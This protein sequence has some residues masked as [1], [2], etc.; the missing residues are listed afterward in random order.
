MIKSLYV[1]RFR[2]MKKLTIPLGKKVTVIAGQNATCKS[3][4]LGMIGQPFGLKSERTIF[5]KPFSTKFSDIFKFS[6]TYDLPGEHEYQIEFYDSSLFGKNVEYI[7][8]Y[9]RASSDTS[10]IR[11]VVGKTRGKGDG[12][13]DYPVIYLGLKRTYPIGELREITESIPTLTQT[14]IEMFNKWYKEIFFPQEKVSPIQ[15]TS[16]LQKD[17]LAV[18]SEKYDYFANS[19]GQDNIGQILGAIISFDRLKTKLGEGYKGGI[20]LIDELDAT[21]F[22]AAQTN[23]VDLFYKLAGKYNLQ[24][25]FTTHSLYTLEHIIE[26]RQHNNNDTEVLYFTNVYGKLDLIVAP[27][28]QRIRSDLNMATI[29]PSPIPKI[30]LYCEDV[31][32][33]WFIKRLLGPQKTKYLNFC[34]ATFGGNFLSSLAEKNIPEFNNSIIIL[35]GDKKPPK[36]SHNVL[37]LPGN[38]NPE[39]V[40]RQLLEELPPDHDFWKNDLGY[41]KQVFEK[42]LSKQTSGRYDDR[43]KMKAWFN[44]QKK[45]WGRGGNNIFKCWLEHHP[46]Q[47]EDFRVQFVRVYNE[48]AKRRSIPTI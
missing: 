34:D 16:K 41:T 43:N 22:P 45:F 25:V 11:L 10:H 7:K 32:A 33:S 14:E 2:A 5:N 3:T 40:F 28:M 47:A 27:Q 20:L 46:E 26:K 23:L 18:N 19:A 9:K 4:L 38:A 42:E 36:A 35:D 13:L 24:F 12:N 6:K 30:N 37:C 8:S 21:L 39:N 31:E 29:S 15:I 17:T 44:N 1:E 48:I